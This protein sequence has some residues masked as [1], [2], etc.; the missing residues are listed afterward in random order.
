MKHNVEFRHHKYIWTKP[1]GSV[2]HHWELVGPRGGIHFHASIF[3]K[4]DD[5]CGLEFH[6]AEPVGYYQNTAPH[7]KDCPVIGGNC[8]HDGTSL[9]ASETLWPVISSYLKS[10]DHDLI[11]RLLEQEFIDHF[12]RLYTGLINSEENS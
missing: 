5:S 10:G 12:S 2:R 1:F 3:E 8:W 7:H 9:Y 4:H 6:H 11:F